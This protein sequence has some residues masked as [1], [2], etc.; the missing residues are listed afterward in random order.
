MIH[1]IKE[2]IHIEPYTITVRYNTGEILA[3]PFKERLQTWATS[4][5]SPFS[6]LLQEDYFTQVQLDHEAET[7][8]WPNGLDFCP[9]TLHDWALEATTSV[10]ATP[11]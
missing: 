11:H 1:L 2:I 3:I 6:R 8:V 10:S 7:L 9:D 4:P 5:D